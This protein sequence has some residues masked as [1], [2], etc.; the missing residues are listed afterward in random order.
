MPISSAGA[1][2]RNSF[3]VINLPQEQKD[4]FA[5]DADL[6]WSARMM[7][8]SVK[9]RWERSTAIRV[10][11]RASIF[12]WRPK[13]SG[14]RLPTSFHVMRNGRR[15][16]NNDG[17]NCETWKST[18]SQRRSAHRHSPPSAARC[19]EEEVRIDQRGFT[20]S[21]SLSDCRVGICCPCPSALLRWDEW[22]VL[23]CLA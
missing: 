17:S 9:S 15:V 2:A 10:H 20:L 6:R 12:L 5:G 11:G 7:E 4:V 3:R 13:Q 14:M 16:W 22:T 8:Q 18:F 23:L 21:K 1:R 19:A